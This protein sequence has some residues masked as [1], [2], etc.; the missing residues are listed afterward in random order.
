MTLV[1]IFLNMGTTYLCTFRNFILWFI[2]C[3][4]LDLAA[5]ILGKITSQ[6]IGSLKRQRQSFKGVTVS[7]SRQIANMRMKIIFV[8]IEDLK[9]HK[10]NTLIIN[11]TL[12]LIVLYGGDYEWW[13]GIVIKL[14][15]DILRKMSLK[16]VN[17]CKMSSSLMSSGFLSSGYK[18][19]AKR[20]H[21]D[22]M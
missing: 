5:W 19:S 17:L 18:I 1:Q 6:F 8:F 4:E 7:Y 3:R 11:Q 14:Y 2:F 10:A 20:R 9:L 16:K 12:R 21:T 15:A 22:I 13:N